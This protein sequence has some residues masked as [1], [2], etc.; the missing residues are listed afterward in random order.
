M[1][2]DTDRAVS[3]DGDIVRIDG[4]P[5]RMDHMVRDAFWANALLSAGRLDEGTAVL[6]HALDVWPAHPTLWQ[7]RYKFLLFS[8]RPRAAAAFALDPDTRP[9]GL[10]QR[11]IDLRIR[12]AKA[13]E[14]R[15][16]AEVETSIGDFQRLAFEDIASVPFAAAVFA[17]L[18][19]PDLTFASLERYYFNEG[20][21]GRSSPVSAMTRRY[22][23]ELFSLPLVPLRSDPQFAAIL[24]RVGLEDYWRQTKTTPDFRRTA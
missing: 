14:T 9:S 15:A 10:D 11:E 6:D 13:A 16:S 22:T 2:A 12:L 18:G 17:L 8:G 3:H 7:M 4:K 21:F 5:V 23:K 19:R 24:G 1:Q 20:A